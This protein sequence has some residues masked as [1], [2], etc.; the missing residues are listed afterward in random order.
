MS[1]RS[2][3]KRRE[4]RDKIPYPLLSKK[5]TKSPLVGESLQ[6]PTCLKRPTAGSLGADQTQGA[7][8]WG[9]M[10]ARPW[11]RTLQRSATCSSP[12]NL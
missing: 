1:S 10:P 8:A 4:S 6:V 2:P 5:P 3:G 11:P 9:V 7:A 12:A